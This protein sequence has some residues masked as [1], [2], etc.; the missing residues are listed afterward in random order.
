MKSKK[1]MKMEI[2]KEG[3]TNEER[4]KNESVTV[5]PSVTVGCVLGLQLI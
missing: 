1:D 2:R 3:S 5:Y 4:K